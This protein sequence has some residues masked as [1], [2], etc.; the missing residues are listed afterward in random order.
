MD[1]LLQR[2]R[3]C[4]ALQQ[5]EWGDPSRL[6]DV[7]AYLRGSPAL[8]RAGDILALRATLARVARG[9]AL[10]VQCGDCAEDMDDHH[11]ENVARKAAVL[12]LLAGALRLA[13]RPAWTIYCNAYGAAKRCSNPNGAIRRA[14]ATCRRTCAAVRR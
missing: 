4:E 12:E 13:G 14:C 11:A 8:I 3:R 10:V 1:D 2:V 9:E 7:Q 6:R 5:P